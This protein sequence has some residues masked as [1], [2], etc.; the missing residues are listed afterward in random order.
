MYMY[1][2]VCVCMCV[3]VHS[4]FVPVCSVYMVWV[5]AC[6]GCVYPLKW[7]GV[8][9]HAHAVCARTYVGCVPVC[10]VCV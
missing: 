2:S 10:V 4:P 1:V 7:C 3:R 6:V 8:G 5:Y 9:V